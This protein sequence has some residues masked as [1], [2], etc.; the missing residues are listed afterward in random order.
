MITVAVE[1]HGRLA[2]DARR[3]L[4]HIATYAATCLRDHSAAPRLVLRWRACLE[5]AVNFSAAD[6]DLLALGCA[7]TASEA[8]VL[9]GRVASAWQL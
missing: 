5:R 3:A 4:D 6:I 8:R 7:P 9:Y 1:F 2:G